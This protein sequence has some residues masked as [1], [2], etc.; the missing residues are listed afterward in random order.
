M[1]QQIKLYKIVSSLNHVEHFDVEPTSD[2][3][4]DEVE[5]ERAVIIS[6]WY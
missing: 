1:T 4:H 6:S 2:S 3:G 5:A